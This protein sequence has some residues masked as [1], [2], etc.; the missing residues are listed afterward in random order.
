VYILD[1]EF[2]EDKGISRDDIK[3]LRVLGIKDN[4]Y[5]HDNNFEWKEGRSCCKNIGV[6]RKRI[7]LVC[8]DEV[9]N[10]INPDNHRE[11]KLKNYDN[12]IRTFKHKSLIILKLLQHI[13]QKL[14]G[15]Y[16]R[17]TTGYD[18]VDDV[19][20]V[21][22][23]LKRYRWLFV[24]NNRLA[25]PESIY[26]HELD[27][28][29]N[30]IGADAE[31]FDILGL[32][33]NVHDETINKFIKIIHE[34]TPT[35]I[36]EI[37]SLLVEEEEIFDPRV[38]EVKD[39]FPEEP[40]SAQDI[41]SFMIAEYNKAPTVTYEKIYK[42]T[43]TSKTKKDRSHLMGKYRGFCQLCEERHMYYC[44]VVE[45]FEKPTK[46]LRQMYLSLCPNCASQ[47][48]ALRRKV[49]VMNKFTNDILESDPR[50]KQKF[51][52]RNGISV[53]FTE[54]HLAEVQAILELMKSENQDKLE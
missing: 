19:S 35:Q 13:T 7:S 8:I 52:L 11:I 45:F 18:I 49:D 33:K 29:Y 21:I 53:R 42:R 6:F 15:Q 32:K 48:K 39:K 10:F 37:K 54:A 20:V 4:L 31:I 43:R 22:K 5:V 47:Y 38:H 26:Y 17:G 40:A 16:K 46:E 41:K 30:E 14:K 23:D 12:N 28:I 51:I 9:L 34:L 25:Q 50:N 44:Q 1:E 24:D 3:Y 36:E 27:S 2:Y